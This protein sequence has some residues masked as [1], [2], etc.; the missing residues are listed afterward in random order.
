MSVLIVTVRFGKSKHK[1]SLNSS[2]RLERRLM[3]LPTANRRGKNCPS[4]SWCRG[5]TAN[6]AFFFLQR[7]VYNF[8]IELS[9]SRFSGGNKEK[10]RVPFDCHRGGE[11][12]ELKGIERLDS[13]FPLSAWERPSS[14]AISPQV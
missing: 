12:N 11:Q 13:F 7:L 14:T 5:G 1:G 8:I 4:I 3:A 6:F 9:C 2:E 10:V